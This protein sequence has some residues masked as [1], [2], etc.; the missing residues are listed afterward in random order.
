MQALE[1]ARGIVCLCMFADGN[2]CFGKVKR[3]VIA[4][5]IEGA[6]D[7]HSCHVQASA[8]QPAH[9]AS[10]QTL[11]QHPRP[12]NSVSAVALLALSIF[13]ITNVIHNQPFHKV[14]SIFLASANFVVCLL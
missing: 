11:Q 3:H 12:S 13:V 7:G 14:E 10:E 2:C 9:L 4:S 6:A 1:R 5:L 8:W